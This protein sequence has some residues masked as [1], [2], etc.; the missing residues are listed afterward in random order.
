M[1]TP[2][3]IDAVLPAALLGY[4]N[5]AP[6]RAKPQEDGKKLKVFYNPFTLGR[7]LAKSDDPTTTSG[8]A[9]AKA[10]MDKLL[11][12]SFGVQPEGGMGILLGV[13]Q[14]DGTSIGGI[15]LDTCRVDEQ[16]TPW[17]G[18]I[19]KLFGSYSETSPSGSGVHALFR[20]KIS[21]LARL[22]A[23]AG[24]GTYSGAAQ[25]PTAVGTG[26]QSKSILT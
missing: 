12:T 13:D 9:L 4:H 26:Q 10:R 11:D 7:E 22:K 19:I 23:A 18:E 25:R 6:W 15:D 8:W 2:R 1:D 14:G 16:F 17:A 20:Y 3:N 5:C 24:V 21:E